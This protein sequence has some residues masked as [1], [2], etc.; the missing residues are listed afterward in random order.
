M[1]YAGQIPLLKWAFWYLFV[2]LNCRKLMDLVQQQK[3]CWW[4]LFIGT[5][6]IDYNAV[7]GKLLTVV[8]ALS[9]SVITA[10]G[11]PMVVVVLSNS[12]LEDMA[13]HRVALEELVLK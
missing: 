13:Y 7:V 8:I 12:L 4:V 6:N 9:V 5:T 3:V 2:V 10:V 11:W 1:Q